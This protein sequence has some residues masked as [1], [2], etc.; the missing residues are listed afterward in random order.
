MV[1]LHECFAC[2]FERMVIYKSGVV[3]AVVLLR[4]PYAHGHYWRSFPTSQHIKMTKVRHSP[5]VNL[6]QGE[7]LVG[8][9]QSLQIYAQ[10]FTVVCGTHIT[11]IRIVSILDDNKVS[12]L[13]ADNSSVTYVRYNAAGKID[14]RHKSI[15]FLFLDFARGVLVLKK[16]DLTYLCDASPYI[17]SQEDIF[18]IIERLNFCQKPSL[19]FTVSGIFLLQENQVFLVRR[20]FC[21]SKSAEDRFAAFE[22]L[23]E[24]RIKHKNMFFS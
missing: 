13:L 9:I 6:W 1:K 2:H 5:T 24:T 21:H 22:L 7:K 19:A 12:N 11:Y 10:A 15:L 3:R 20:M 23:L 17:S 4:M 14:S 8:D 16:M 18:R